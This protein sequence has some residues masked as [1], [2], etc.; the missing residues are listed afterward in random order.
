MY[1]LNF[2]QVVGSMIAIVYVARNFVQL[3]AEKLEGANRE[4]SDESKKIA[5]H[6]LKSFRVLHEFAKD[7]GIIPTTERGDGDSDG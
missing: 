3:R 6:S 2:V 1:Y 7:Q 5:N 4:S